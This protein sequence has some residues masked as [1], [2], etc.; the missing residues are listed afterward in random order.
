MTRFRLIAI[1]A[2]IMAFTSSAF[3]QTS[4][5]FFVGNIADQ[6]GAVVSGAVMKITNTNTGVTRETTSN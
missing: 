4:K 2:I 5:G 3:G 1:A 6:N